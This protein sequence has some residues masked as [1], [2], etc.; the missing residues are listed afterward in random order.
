MNVYTAGVNKGYYL[1]WIPVENKHQVYSQLYLVFTWNNHVYTTV[2]Y[3]QNLKV[4]ISSLTQ[5]IQGF[6]MQGLLHKT[7]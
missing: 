6:V 1:N 2:F 7:F 4:A 5:S 3:S